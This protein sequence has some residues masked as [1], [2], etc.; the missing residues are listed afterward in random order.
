MAHAPRPAF[1]ET[2]AA[3]RER[4]P[5]SVRNRNRN[6][7]PG[8]APGSEPP[9]QSAPLLEKREGETVH[10]GVK[11][12]LGWEKRERWLGG[13]NTTGRAVVDASPSAPAAFSADLWR[14][15]P[16]AGLSAREPA[17]FPQGVKQLLPDRQMIDVGQL[18][19]VWET[20]VIGGYPLD[21]LLF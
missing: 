5:W 13:G 11:G 18:A 10:L 4:L 7:L 16:E 20:F 19:P 15:P 6:P 12:V 9:H 3:R 21:G 2:S 1:A 17:L 8:Q 14:A